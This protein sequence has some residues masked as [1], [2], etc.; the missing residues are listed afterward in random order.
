MLEGY[1]EE[2]GDI[3]YNFIIG[4]DGHAYEGRGFN[5]QGLIVRDDYLVHTDISG[6]VVSFI[7]GENSTQPSEGQKD[8]LLEFLTQSV[9]R[10]L[11]SDDYI[12][13]CQ[14]SINMDPDDEFKKFL[15]ETFESRYFERNLTF[16]CAFVKTY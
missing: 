16:D 4:D 3:P 7:V 12:V 15:N 11:V 8:T 9:R 1:T 2:F 13:I 10:G 5:F 6:L 14:S